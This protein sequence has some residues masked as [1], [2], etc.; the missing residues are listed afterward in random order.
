MGQKTSFF[1][2]ASKVEGVFTSNGFVSMI[3]CS[4]PFW[5]TF[6]HPNILMSSHLLNWRKKKFSKFWHFSFFFWPFLR[7]FSLLR[8]AVNSVSAILTNGL[9]LKT[10]GY[11]QT[12]KKFNFPQ[13]S[14]FVKFESTLV[15]F[16]SS[17]CYHPGNAIYS[18]L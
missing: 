7:I 8:I 12:M 16:R 13:P 5:G 2:E 18:Y 4:K 3:R 11:C 6:F 9:R 17:F 15:D 14:I 1:H 10:F